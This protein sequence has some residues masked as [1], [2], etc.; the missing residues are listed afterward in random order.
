MVSNCIIG[1]VLIILSV[2]SWWGTS[3]VLRKMRNLKKQ[4]NTKDNYFGNIV[5]GIVSAIIVV[6][7]QQFVASA[8][9]LNTPSTQSLA[10][11]LLGLATFL[12]NVLFISSVTMFI[13]LWVYFLGVKWT[14]AQ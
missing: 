5:A 13:V 11:F 14:R 9:L 4:R 7:L 2:L 1:L 12:I 6:V 8:S 3:V 10:A